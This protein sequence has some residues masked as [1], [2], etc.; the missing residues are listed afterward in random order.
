MAKAHAVI[1]T[2]EVKARKSVQV[3]LT[4]I[5]KKQKQRT[6]KQTKPKAKKCRYVPCG[7]RGGHPRVIL[8]KRQNI[9]LRNGGAVSFRGTR[10]AQGHNIRRKA[11]RLKNQMS[12]GAEKQVWGLES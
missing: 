9:L 11:Q 3:S 6:V 2:L 5:A 12:L 8:V 4:Y 7:S 1:L 10:P